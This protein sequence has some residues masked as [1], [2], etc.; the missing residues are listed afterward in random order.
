MEV[1]RKRHPEHTHDTRYAKKK[2]TQKQTRKLIIDR[3][4]ALLIEI[5]ELYTREEKEPKC[6]IF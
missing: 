4:R 5:E 6:V 1:S 2:R 3:L